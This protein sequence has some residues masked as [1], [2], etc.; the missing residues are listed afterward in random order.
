MFL[1]Y[2]D[3]QIVNALRICIGFPIKFLP[4]KIPFCSS[5]VKTCSQRVCL[6]RGARDQREDYTVSER[7]PDLFIFPNSV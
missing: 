6:L 1:Y 7:S 3:V 4:I 5:R 2:A